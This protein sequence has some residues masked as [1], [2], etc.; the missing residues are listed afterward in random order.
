MKIVGIILLA[1]TA[2]FVWR[3]MVRGDALI[4]VTP[5]SDKRVTATMKRIVPAKELVVEVDNNSKESRVTQISLARSLVAQLGMS[6]PA[7]FKEEL[8]PLTEKE[9]KD[10]DS[11]AF[12]EKYNKDNIRWIGTLVVPPDAKA[13][14]VFPITTGADVKGFIQFQYEA[15]WGLGG[16]IS[17]F[18]AN[19][20]TPE[21]NK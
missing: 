20:G 19:L 7:G 9:K 4:M 21:P 5:G 2:Y 8:L 17:H 15:K 11:V 18:R 13:E 12:V 6:P 10:N 1:L 3:F 14:V 16:S